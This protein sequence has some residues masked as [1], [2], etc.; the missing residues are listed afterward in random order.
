MR[1]VTVSANYS[2][3]DLNSVMKVLE[4]ETKKRMTPETTYSVE[5]QG[6]IMAESMA[7]FATT[8]LLAIILV[9]MVLAAQFESYMTP[10]VIMLS[11]TLSFVGAILGLLI[12]G[13]E[14]SMYPMIGI[15][16]LVGIVTKNAIL[17]IDF[18]LQRMRAGMPV[19]EALLEAGP[20]RLRPIL[21]T[22]FAMIF[23]MIPIAIGHGEGGEARSPMAVAVIGGLIT[24]TV[25]TLVIIPCVFSLFQGVKTWYYGKKLL[26][27]T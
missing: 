16:L 2:G 6:R 17:L 27:H 18:A 10:L 20:I 3:K 4:S 15:L 19:N 5:G 14:F 24:S 26:E 9:W 13:R 12:T 7:S 1:S 21:M 11:V 25:L 22:T 23:G 8:L